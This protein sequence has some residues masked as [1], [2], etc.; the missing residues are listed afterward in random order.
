MII[1]KHYNENNYCLVHKNKLFIN[2]LVF[3]EK[4][5]Y[6]YEKIFSKNYNKISK[7]ASKLLKDKNLKITHTDV[8]Y[9]DLVYKMKKTLLKEK[10]E[11]FY[12]LMSETFCHDALETFCVYNNKEKIFSLKGEKYS[13]TFLVTYFDYKMNSILNSDENFIVDNLNLRDI[14]KKSKK[15]KE[16]FTD[17]EINKYKRYI[18]FLYNKYKKFNF[19]DLYIRFDFISNVSGHEARKILI[20]SYEH[21]DQFFNEHIE[22]IMKTINL[23]ERLI[24]FY[25]YFKY[26]FTFLIFLDYIRENKIENKIIILFSCIFAVDHI[27]DFLYNKNNYIINYYFTLKEKLLLFFDENISNEERNELIKNDQKKNKKI[28]KMEKTTFI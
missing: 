11:D 8:N 21:Y 14:N 22:N 1:I 5:F 13:S 18:N 6:Y 9:Y 28:L 3:Y 25:Q 4:K 16:Y 17:K 27:K 12:Y 26:Y 2:M 10:E 19:N 15:I 20:K 7:I 23:G 24:F